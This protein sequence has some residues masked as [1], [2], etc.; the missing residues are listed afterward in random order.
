[1]RP[2]LQGGTC[3]HNHR[4]RIPVPPIYIQAVE[5]RLV[6]LVRPFALVAPDPGVIL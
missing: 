3:R 5:E 6:L 1:M 2:D 4:E